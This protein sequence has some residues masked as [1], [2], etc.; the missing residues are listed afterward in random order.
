MARVDSLPEGAKEVLQIGSV[1][2]REFS[3]ELLRTATGL[4]E[5]ELLPRLSILKDSELLY[6]RGI[7]PKITY[8][9][10][11]ALTREVVYDSIL[12]KRRKKLHGEIGNAIEK[13][14]RESINEYFGI[15]AEHYAMGEDWEKGAE[16]SQL[17][18]ENAE[19]A[20]SMN[21]AI[22]YAEKRVT[23]LENVPRT[24]DVQK[25]IIDARTALGVYMSRM[26]HYAKAKEAVEPIIDIAL[27]S[28]NKR[29]LPQ[30]LTIIGNH[31]YCVKED[32]PKAFEYLEEAV[33]TSEELNDKVS[34]GFAIWRLGL[35]LSLNCEFEKASHCFQKVLDIMEA[36]NSLWGMSLA[37]SYLSIFCYFWWGRIS[38]AYQTSDEAVRMAEESGD[39][40]STAMAY[41][42]RGASCYGKGFMDQATRHLLKGID[43][44][45]RINMGIFSA[46]AR[47][48][49]AE[50]YYE[51][52][53]YQD[54]KDHYARAAWLAK[55]SGGFLSLVTH[56]EVGAMK[57]KVMMD[58]REI[59]L[60]KLYAYA[61]E[62]KLRVWDGWKVTFITEILLNMDDQHMS[63]AEEW[64]KKAVKKHKRDGMIW[65]L[66]RDFTLYAELLKRKG[67]KLKSKENLI[68]AIEIF[69]ECGAVGWVT[70]TERKLVS[71]S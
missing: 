68:K 15:L 64:A 38:L 24:D 35:A 53:D 65:Y 25:D 63:E 7:Y 28:G 69:K 34:L 16:Y 48:I 39:I 20:G 13:S 47:F 36:E 2:E 55:Q 5:I 66:A 31:E 42:A 43:Y 57:A 44:S 26:F 9:F 37:K 50:V 22:S 46:V 56:N 40:Y 30:I 49:L 3:Y 18:A 1:I 52:G 70:R 8:I 33:K 32:V 51:I 62:N 14:C 21:N 4:S 61:Y 12:S 23:C 58:E 11:H 6:E 27:K 59:D 67:D 60:E 41:T 10:K 45:E 17:A 29:R 19:R 54:S 71:F